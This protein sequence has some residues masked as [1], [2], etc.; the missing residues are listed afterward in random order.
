MSIS[1]VKSGR[2]FSARFR[3]RNCLGIWIPAFCRGALVDLN[4][5]GQIFNKQFLPE[6]LLNRIMHLEH[7]NQHGFEL[8]SS[9]PEEDGEYEIVHKDYN[10]ACLTKLIKIENGKYQLWDETKSDTGWGK[11]EGGWKQARNI[12][13]IGKWVDYIVMIRVVRAAHLLTREEALEKLHE[14]LDAGEIGISEFQL[15]LNNPNW[16]LDL[17]A[18]VEEAKSKCSPAITE[19]TMFLVLAKE[20][21]VLSAGS[22]KEEALKEI[23]EWTDSEIIFSEDYS[24]ASNNDLVLT[25]CTESFFEAARDKNFQLHTMNYRFQSNVLQLN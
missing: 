10:A 8:A 13:R 6:D 19:D 25:K 14:L 15:I 17:E 18:A 11:P 22:T 16:L 7:S 2:I 21:A 20:E 4:V 24:S 1:I 12:A 9:L 3:S 23:Q 5:D